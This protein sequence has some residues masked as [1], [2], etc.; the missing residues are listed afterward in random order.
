MYKSELWL[1]F[2]R[3]TFSLFPSPDRYQNRWLLLDIS[4]H[5]LL[6]VLSIIR[7]ELF[8][9]HTVCDRC[10][11]QTF[12]HPQSSLSVICVVSMSA[13]R[14]CTHIIAACFSS[15]SNQEIRFESK[16]LIDA[17][18]KPKSSRGGESVSQNTSRTCHGFH[19]NKWKEIILSWRKWK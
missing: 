8:I 6:L 11:C 13:V 9:L 10:R 19:R 16:T 18:W 2:Y 17:S 12:Y 1:L 3:V 15:V 4:C 5:S 14:I 7:A